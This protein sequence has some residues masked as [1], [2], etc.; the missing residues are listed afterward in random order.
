M[1]NRKINDLDVDCELEELEK[2]LGSM[3]NEYDVEYPS[4]SEMMRTIDAIRP[5]VPVKDNKWRIYLDNMASIF[6]HS[7]QEFFYISPIFWI[8]NSLF[9]LTGLVAVFISEQSP[10]ATIMI[11]APIPTITGL[12]EVFKSRNGNMAELE[13]SFKFSL[14]EIILSKMI[15]VSGFNI[16]INLLVTLIISYFHQDILLAKLMLYWIIPFMVITA[17]CLVIVN[18]IRHTYAVT[19]G[20]L[21]WIGFGSLVSQTR[22]TEKIENMPKLI[23][24]LVIVMAALLIIFQMKQLNK[25]GVTYEFNH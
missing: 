1:S 6:K 4:E 20:L 18:R 16:I 17:I 23:Y 19:A 22:V 3:L 5:Y 11:L 21:V 13:M 7:I 24:V 9:L 14:Q 12:L 2:K 8:V 25:R 10:Y 15:V